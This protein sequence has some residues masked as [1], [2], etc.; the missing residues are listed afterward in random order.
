VPGSG[1]EALDGL[2]IQI[3]GNDALAKLL[4]RSESP[5]GLIST[6]SLCSRL[7]SSRSLLP[8]ALHQDLLMLCRKIC[9]AKQV[10]SEYTMEWH[11]V[12]GARVVEAAEWLVL[13]MVCF[14]C[15]VPLATSRRGLAL[16]LVNAGF[17]ALERA[18]DTSSSG[19]PHDIARFGD[20]VF[21][22]IMSR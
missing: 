17:R 7:T 14:T 19:L 21:N 12:P 20:A 18:G 10:Y 8:A 3:L 9:V 16:H 22:A 5:P 13:A 1:S 11:P 2:A 4:A 6:M 15:A